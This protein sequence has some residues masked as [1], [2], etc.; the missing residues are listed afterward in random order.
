[1]RAMKGVAH[2]VC[3]AGGH[4]HVV[5]PVIEFAVDADRCIFAYC[6]GRVCGIV[7]AGLHRSISLRESTNRHGARRHGGIE[8]FHVALR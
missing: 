1:M 5:S 2:V 6:I 4:N 3:A 7:R 8:S